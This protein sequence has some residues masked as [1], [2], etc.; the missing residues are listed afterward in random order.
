MENVE[1]KDAQAARR[2]DREG[3]VDGSF[4]RTN[5]GLTID[6]CF[7]PTD[8]SDPFDTVQWDLRIAAIKEEGGGTLF[9]QKDCEVPSTWSQLA[10]NGR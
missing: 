8:V 3:Q 1:F 2:S 7:C 4:A 5:Q 10:T 9:E 6:P